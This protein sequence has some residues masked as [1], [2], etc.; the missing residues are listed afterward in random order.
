MNQG[1]NN[2]YTALMFKIVTSDCSYLGSFTNFEEVA[3]DEEY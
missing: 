1:D 3:G 2:G